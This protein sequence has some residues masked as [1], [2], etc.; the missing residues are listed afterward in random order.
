MA[1]SAENTGD[2]REIMSRGD[3]RW[4]VAGSV[5]VLTGLG[6]FALRDHRASWRHPLVSERATGDA[7]QGFSSR[8]FAAAD[9][10]LPP[11]P[12]TPEMTDRKAHV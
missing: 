11:P 9:T 1:R 8:P 2:R 5:V 7:F 4:I 3:K 12:E 10:K 6:W